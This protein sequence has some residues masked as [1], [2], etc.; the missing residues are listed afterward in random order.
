MKYGGVDVTIANRWDT[1]QAGV[2]FTYRFGKNTIAPSR[3]RD[4]GVSDEINRVG[5]GK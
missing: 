3:R 5:Q 4:N 2:S 1:R